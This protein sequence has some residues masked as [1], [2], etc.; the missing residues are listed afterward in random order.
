MCGIGLVLF[1]SGYENPNHTREEDECNSLL[2]QTLSSRGPDVPCQSCHHTVSKASLTLHASVLHMRGVNPSAQP[3]LFPLDKSLGNDR[4]AEPQSNHD[5]CSFCWNGECYTYVM[6]HNLLEHETISNDENRYEYATITELVTYPNEHELIE[7][8]SCQ[9]DTVL[10]KNLLLQ[11]ISGTRQSKG[12]TCHP[13]AYLEQKAVAET[14]ARIHG[15]YSFLIYVPSS[16]SNSTSGHVYYGRDVLGRRSLLINRSMDNMV[17]ISSVATESIGAGD[18]TK[19][20]IFDSSWEELPPGIVYSMDV[21]TGEVTSLPIPRIISREVQTS[22]SPTE[23]SVDAAAEQLLF[24]LDKSVQRRVM[25]APSPKSLCHSDASVAILFS[26]GI[27]SVVLA[28]L[29]HRHIPPD[30]AIDL[31]NVSFYDDADSSMTVTPDRLAA[32]CSFSEMTTKWPERNWRFIAVDVSYKEVL[33]VEANV[34]RLI[35]PLESTMDFN[36]AVAFWFAGRGKGQI[37][38]KSSANEVFKGIRHQPAMKT[39]SAFQPLLRHAHTTS[40]DEKSETPHNMSRKRQGCV[41]DGCNR[42]APPHGCIF[43]ACKFCCGK[44]QSPISK[45]LGQRVQICPVHNRKKEIAPSRA[46]ALSS[47]NKRTSKTITSTAKILISGVGADEQCAGYGRHRTTF[48]R[49]GYDELKGELQ[50]EVRRLWIRNLGRDDRCL[51]DCG[52]EARFPFLDEDVVAYLE[53]LPIPLKCDMS[54]PQGEGDKLILRKVARQIGVLEC[55]AL[56]KRAIQFGSRIAK[57]S[58][59]NRF[60]SQRQ[61]NG[62][63]KHITWRKL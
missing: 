45:F 28:V 27:D 49:G 32:L 31:I 4:L 1:L 43:N 55:S 56:V 10:V 7:P 20:N 61:A 52:K 25:N 23:P 6:D 33:D 40:N 35:N 24:L 12:S 9:S 58:D 15:E 29:S 41:R 44:L 59:K 19:S 57:V 39:S 14:M 21:T 8:D 26:G 5:S 54:L 62:E 17:V 34:L 3:L 48:Q 63:A 2:S 53:A 50:M 47:K 46:D 11:S 38:S 22:L 60:G 18:D 36:I 16:S 51:S 13:I 37:V 42:L 30:R